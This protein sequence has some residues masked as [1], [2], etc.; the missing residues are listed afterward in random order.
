[1]PVTHQWNQESHTPGEKNYAAAETKQVIV[2]QTLRDEK[3]GTDKEQQPASKVKTFLRFSDC[4]DL[5]SRECCVPRNI[6]T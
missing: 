5:L 4:S 3:D 1:M 2:R 6:I